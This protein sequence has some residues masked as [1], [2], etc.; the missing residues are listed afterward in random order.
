[1][2]LSEQAQTA[3]QRNAVN[4]S[5]QTIARCGLQALHFSVFMLND[6]KAG[7]HTLC[8]MYNSTGRQ[9]EYCTL[10]SHV[11]D[12]QGLP[13]IQE[14][15]TDEKDVEI[16]DKQHSREGEHDTT[17]LTTTVTAIMW[18]LYKLLHDSIKSEHLYSTVLQNERPSQLE[19]PHLL[20]AMLLEVRSV[21]W[22]KIDMHMIR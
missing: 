3:F 6:T 1:M 15:N 4:Q 11:A 16:C 7:W 13:G 5:Q 14:P 8:R 19:I 20:Y 9:L 10:K 2:P 17:H 21:V 22:E 12:M 18:Y